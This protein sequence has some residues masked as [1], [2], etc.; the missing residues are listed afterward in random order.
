MFEPTSRYAGLPVA[1]LT[2]A[3]ADGN[4]RSVRYVTRRFIPPRAGAT[5]LAAHT[6]IEGERVDTIA[7]RHL[8]DP[9]LFWRI[10]DAN[11]VLR[12]DELVEQP[13]RVITIVLPGL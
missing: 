11:G 4:P 6:V 2:I 3:D 7:A 5:E 13:G 8:G 12:P 10:C 1:T 9:L